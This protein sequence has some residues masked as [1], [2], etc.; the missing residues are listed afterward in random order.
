MMINYNLR[1]I[2]S[3]RCDLAPA[4]MQEALQWLKESLE[5]SLEDRD[6]ENLDGQALV[7]L[8]AESAAAMDAPSFQ[9][10]LRAA[11]IQ[12]PDQEETYWRIP[13]TM[14]VGTIKKRCEIIVAAL[15]GEFIE[16]GT[17]L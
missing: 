15:R 10:F 8:T 2:K 5:E 6:E 14:L 7:P 17:W 12:Q 11:G 3:H 9:R 13:A 4:E 1:H 16:E